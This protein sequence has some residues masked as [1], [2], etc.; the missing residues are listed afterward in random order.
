MADAKALRREF[1]EERGWTERGVNLLLQALFN[2]CFSPRGPARAVS[3]AV[4]GAACSVEMD[5]YD[6]VCDEYPHFADK[7]PEALCVDH[8]VTIALKQLV[9]PDVHGIHLEDLVQRRRS[10]ALFFDRN[11]PF[12]HQILRVWEAR[13]WHRRSGALR[14]VSTI[15]ET[16]R[17]ASAALQAADFL[18]WHMNRDVA[19][20]SGDLQARMMLHFA[21]RCYVQRYDYDELVETAQRWG[22]DHGYKPV[23]GPDPE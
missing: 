15:G 10:I 5:A 12:R 9:P 11:E 7:A 22:K 13:P 23:L 8:V 18:A 16:D 1:T 21:S 2:R 17:E 4:V 19:S 14:L 20:V 3:D 6:R